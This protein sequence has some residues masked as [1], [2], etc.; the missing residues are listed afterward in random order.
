MRRSFPTLYARASTGKVKFWEV[1]AETVREGT[2][3]A[4][5]HPGA[6][7]I[8]IRY[9]YV[10][11]DVGKIQETS[12][13]VLVG[14]NLGRAN[15]TTPFQQAC[16]EAASLWEKKRDRKYVEDPTGKSSL[17]LPMLAHD[18]TKRGRAIQWKEGAFVQPKLDGCR[19]LSRKV[20]EQK[21]EYFS[22]GGKKY[23]TLSHLD[24]LLLS[25]LRVGE[26]LDGEVFT[27]D[28]TFQEICSAVK[29]VKTQN[30]DPTLLQYWFYDLVSPQQTFRERHQEMS[31]RA[32]SILSWPAAKTQEV[33][34]F[35]P[36]H[37]CRSEA[38]MKR[39]HARFVEEGFEGTIIR[40]AQGLYRCDFR[41]PDLQKFKD[42]RDAE[43]Q[44]VGGKEGTGR[45]AG[46]IIWTCITEN[47]KVFDVRPRGTDAERRQWWQNLD[48][49]VGQ[50]LTVRYQKLSDEGIPIFPV[51][52]GIRN[53]E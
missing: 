1:E 48:Q 38:E 11:Q 7:R 51:G 20:S 39:Y 41:S 21:I 19:L 47:G 8:N 30:Q 53:Y 46:T 49:Y 2:S 26:T 50:K 32:N 45:A 42:F 40:N 27:F 10:G 5:D 34:V 43:Y 9:G 17:L 4:L 36:T 16:L 14:K 6:S 18:Y 28:L 29:G 33:L 37:E 13:L 25:F 35:T 15:A 12:R 23:H 22:R 3:T 52:I 44:I 31:R 24:D